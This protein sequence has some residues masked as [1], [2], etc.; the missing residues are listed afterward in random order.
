MKVTYKSTNHKEDPKPKFAFD[1]EV[2]D[3]K[4][5]SYDANK[6]LLIM[7]LVDSMQLVPEENV[8]VE[9]ICQY[10]GSL[11]TFTY[12]EHEKLKRFYVRNKLDENSDHIVDTIFSY[13]CIYLFPKKIKFKNLFPETIKTFR[14]NAKRSEK[15]KPNHRFA[16]RIGRRS[17]SA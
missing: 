3:E 8:I 7:F 10:V 1:L 6:E 17:L 16:S 9:L 14:T 13:S 11:P 4:P 15:E 5:S 2:S 12:F